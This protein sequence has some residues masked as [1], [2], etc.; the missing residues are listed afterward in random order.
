[1]PLID[2]I[3]Q[4]QQ[5]YQQGVFA[6]NLTRGNILDFAIGINNNNQAAR[7]ISLY[8]FLYNTLMWGNFDDIVGRYKRVTAQT[9]L[10]EIN[11]FNQYSTNF[12]SILDSNNP[13]AIFNSFKYGDL[14]IRNVGES[15]FTKFMHFYSYG[16]NQMNKFIIIDKWIK[17]AWVALVF[18]LE[19]NSSYQI[20]LQSISRYKGKYKVSPFNERKFLHCL[21]DLKNIAEINQIELSRFEELIFGWDLRIENL[22]LTNPRIEMLNILDQHL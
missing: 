2:I 1:M 20:A 5:T 15:Y 3:N 6:N 12:I 7:N 18:E 14:K 22:G 13:T 19:I 21:N 16:K 4:N 17:I 10:E 9:V 11:N 8:N